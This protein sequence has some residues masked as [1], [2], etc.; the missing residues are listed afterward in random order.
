MLMPPRD[1]TY[2]EYEKLDKDITQ[3]EIDELYSIEVYQKYIENKIKE[4]IRKKNININL[5]DMSVD[6]INDIEYLTEEQNKIIKKL[7]REERK[8]KLGFDYIENETQRREYIKN[9]RNHWME[10]EGI[11]IPIGGR[12]KMSYKS[13]KTNKK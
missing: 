4:L 13:R 10:L 6:G 5:D 11:T 9:W 2:E 12:K 8:Y 7:V 1:L 3:E